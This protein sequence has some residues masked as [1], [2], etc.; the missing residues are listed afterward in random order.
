MTP[1]PTEGGYSALDAAL[2]EEVHAVDELDQAGL[3][4]AGTQTLEA[5]IEAALAAAKS[6]ERTG[7]G[8]RVYTT[9]E[10]AELL[11]KSPTWLYSAT[12]QKLFRYSDGSAIEPLRVGSNGRRRYT[13][14]MI[15]GMARSCLRHHVLNRREF[16]Q[17]LAELSRT[18]R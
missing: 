11:G 10:V 8:E 12:R 6:T 3:A 7:R 5:E 18:E 14:S 16:E 4:A 13:G 17:V 2:R 9:R 15:R 1:C